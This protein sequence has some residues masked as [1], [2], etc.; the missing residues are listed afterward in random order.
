VIDL[1][2]DDERDPNDI[3]IQEQFNAFSGMI[4]VKTVAAA[5]S[6]L[7]Q[8]SVHF[9]SLDHDLGTTESGYDLAKWIEERAYRGE[10]KRLH[11]AVHSM[12]IEGAKAIRV[13]MQNA[14]KYWRSEESGQKRLG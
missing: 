4:W 1:W 6:R 8:G 7:R 11:W 2:L 3:R 13:A 9:I 5:I 10:I 12:N 14:D